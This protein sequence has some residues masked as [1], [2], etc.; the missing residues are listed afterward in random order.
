M[1]VLTYQILTTSKP[2]YL[3]SYFPHVDDNIRRSD[4]IQS[5]SFNIPLATTSTLSNS[6]SIQAIKLWDSIP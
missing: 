3:T 5:S 6:F 4:R 2:Q 1:A